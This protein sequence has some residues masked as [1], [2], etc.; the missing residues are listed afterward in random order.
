MLCLVVHLSKCHG[1]GKPPSSGS[2]VIRNSRKAKGGNGWGRLSAHAVS[3]LIPLAP[4]AL[5]E[6]DQN[7]FCLFLLF[8]P[9][10]S[11]VLDD[12]VSEPSRARRA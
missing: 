7:S 10:S 2:L 3:T 6:A 9:T 1:S 4:M 11:P 12:R 5:A 8:R